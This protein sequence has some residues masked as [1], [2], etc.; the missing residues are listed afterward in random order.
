MLHG[1]VDQPLDQLV[2]PQLIEQPEDAL[3]DLQSRLVRGDGEFQIFE[4]DA[5]LVR[6]QRAQCRES[7]LCSFSGSLI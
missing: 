5:R 6:E 1:L 2:L 4:F 7:F 3:V